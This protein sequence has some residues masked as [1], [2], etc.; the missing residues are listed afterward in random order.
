MWSRHRQAAGADPAASFTAALG[1]ARAL[2]E[3]GESRPG[4]FTVGGR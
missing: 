1:D 3:P 4:V 2:A